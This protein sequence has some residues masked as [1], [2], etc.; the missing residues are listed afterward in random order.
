MKYAIGPRKEMA[1][2]TIFNLLGPLTN[3][4][5]TK[6]QVMGVFDKKWVRPMAEV[7][8]RLGSEHVM[9]VHS[10]D[11]LDEISIAAPT[12]VAELKNGEIKEY[13][14]SPEDFKNGKTALGVTA[15]R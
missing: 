4:A 3:P 6:H 7:L 2:R 10:E 12:Y 13:K 11:G 1:V 9:I 5:N 8:Q 14:I 15:S